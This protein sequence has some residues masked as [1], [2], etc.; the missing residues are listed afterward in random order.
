[1]GIGGKE[2]EVEDLHKM[3]NGGK[4]KMGD[5]VLKGKWETREILKYF[6][7][8]REIHR[9]SAAPGDTLFRCGSSS[10]ILRF[11]RG[12][13]Q[14]YDVKKSGCRDKQIIGESIYEPIDEGRHRVFE[15]TGAVIAS[16][17]QSWSQCRKKKFNQLMLGEFIGAKHQDRYLR[18]TWFTSQYIVVGVKPTI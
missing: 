1:M 14:R 4:Q 17:A 15:E 6:A 12:S 10:S 2:R 18:R 3:E 8:K 5:F 13:I 7:G 16:E 9:R 11:S